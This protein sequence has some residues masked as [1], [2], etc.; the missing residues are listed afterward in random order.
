MKSK[1]ENPKKP[2]A[3]KGASKS[4][5]AGAS[6][7]QKLSARDAALL[8]I[9]TLSLPGWRARSIKRPPR[10]KLQDVRDEA[11]AETLYVG[12]IKNLILLQKLI[13]HHSGKRLKQIDPAVQKVIALAIYQIR[14]LTR[15]PA[16]AAVDEA[17]EQTKRLKLG[18]A[19][20][21]VN[22]VL[23]K[24]ASDKEWMP[25]STNMI[26]QCEIL[27]SHPA[28]LVK[29]LAK[30]VR[31]SDLIAVCQQHN[32]EPPTLLR[33]RAE[34]DTSELLRG[35]VEIAPHEV[36]GFAVVRGAT[37]ADFA[38]WADRGLAQVQD[39]GTATLVRQ[40]PLK[41]GQSVLDRCCGHGTKTLQ[42]SERV[43]VKGTVTAMDS[44]VERVASL[45][46]TLKRREILNVT[47]RIESTI[48]AAGIEPESFDLVLIDSPCSN[49]GVL[50][51]RPEA[52]YRQTTKHLES[53]ALAQRELLNDSAPAVSVGGH[54]AYMTCSVWPE[55]NERVVEWFIRKHKNFAL[56]MTASHQLKAA[57]SPLRYRD[58]GFLAVFRRVS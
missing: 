38:D 52:R 55:E 36:K 16:H 39:A 13:E 50:G 17:V 2:T 31:P 54:L 33:L 8:R 20:A 27:H 57:E 34:L 41:N 32:A 25:E 19:D 11:L 12:V 48:A 46:R 29:M 30:V 1:P 37:R 28:E 21:F 43:G 3:S 22:A 4:A 15:I 18:R 53:L 23:R 35:G 58:G 14:F 5:N 51:R 45:Q 10:G 40:L 6:E 49:S 7:G 47:T 9:D 56:A 26:E 44:S 24:A 42:L